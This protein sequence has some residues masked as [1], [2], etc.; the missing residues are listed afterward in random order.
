MAL[1]HKHLQL[2]LPHATDIF[3][4][5]AALIKESSWNGN[6]REKLQGEEDHLISLFLL[7]YHVAAAVATLLAPNHT[8]RAL[9][10]AKGDA[11]GTAFFFTLPLVKRRPVCLFMQRNHPITSS[12]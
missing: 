1:L 5:S 7:V 2:L 12:P 9:Q 8:E 3:S 10:A 4:R 11:H 6:I